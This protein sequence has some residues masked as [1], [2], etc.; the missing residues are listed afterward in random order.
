VV[1][2]GCRWVRRWC[3]GA[4]AKV[5]AWRGDPEGAEALASEAVVLASHTDALN[6]RR[7]IDGPGR[8]SPMLYRGAGLSFSPSWNPTTQWAGATPTCGL[9]AECGPTH[10]RAPAHGASVLVSWPLA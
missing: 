2:A 10:A 7:R 3:G 9:D 4:Q 6:L 8:G 5:L 1:R